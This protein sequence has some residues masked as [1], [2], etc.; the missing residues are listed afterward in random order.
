M[1]TSI[2]TTLISYST[3]PGHS[4][5]A[6][7]ESRFMRKLP[8]T[9]D[10]G[11]VSCPAED[12]VF[13]KIFDMMHF[14]CH[15]VSRSD[16]CHCRPVIG[17]LRHGAMVLLVHISTRILSSSIVRVIVSHCGNFRHG[18]LVVYS[19][20][21]VEMRF[22]FRQELAVVEV[23]NRCVL[24]LSVIWSIYGCLVNICTCM[25]WVGG[26]VVVNSK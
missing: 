6:R 3:V 22:L 14:V 24:Y 4:H 16:C 18:D 2:F 19:L 11:S 8:N 15:M 12:S 26:S 13:L 21:H 10:G 23:Q 17:L 1:H 25:V 5:N 7:H 20:F 9:R